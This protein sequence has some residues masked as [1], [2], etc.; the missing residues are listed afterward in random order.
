MPNLS[1]TLWRLSPSSLA[2][3][4]RTA[5]AALTHIDLGAPA[6]RQAFGS[7]TDRGTAY[8][9]A[10]RTLAERPDLAPRLSAATNLTDEIITSIANQV[11]T[12]R[13]W[14]ASLG[15]NRLHFELPIQVRA[16]DGSETNAIIA[17]GCLQKDID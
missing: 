17:L 3:Q 5:I 12:L 14:L 16:D 1:R 8:H 4:N 10:F 7:A 13:A 11:T 2:E 9:L 6:G 15:F